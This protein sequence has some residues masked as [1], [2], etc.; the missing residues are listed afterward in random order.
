M[1]CRVTLAE[2]SKTRHN[3]KYFLRR[4]AVN[5]TPD[6]LYQFDT[7]MFTRPISAPRVTIIVPVTYNRYP[8]AVKNGRV[9]HTGIQ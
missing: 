1:E 7:I 5:P 2:T 8:R 4:R 6:D 9:F 3:S